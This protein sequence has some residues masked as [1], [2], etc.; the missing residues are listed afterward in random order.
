MFA[1]I[2]YFFV[3]EQEL[4]VDRGLAIA[5]GTTPRSFLWLVAVVDKKGINW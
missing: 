3:F 1:V 4:N 5:D 2:K